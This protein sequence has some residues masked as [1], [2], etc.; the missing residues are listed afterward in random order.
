MSGYTDVFTQQR[1]IGADSILNLQLVD[2]TPYQFYWP[3][4]NEDQASVIPGYLRI[5]SSVEGAGIV[6]PDA[7]DGSPGWGF[8]VNNLSTNV[9]NVS[10]ANGY[11]LLSLS[12]GQSFIFNLV[13]DT[14]LAGMWDYTVIG[15]VVSTYDATALAGQGLEAVASK[16]NAAW[17]ITYLSTSRD[18]GSSDRGTVINWTGGSG[19]LTLI[20]TDFTGTGFF[21]LIR[22][23]GTGPISVTP[24][25]GITLDE[26][27]TPLVI[28]PNE[29]AVISNDQNDWYSLLYNKNSSNVFNAINIAV[30]PRRASRTTPKR[31]PFNNFRFRNANSCHSAAAARRIQVEWRVW[32]GP[33]KI[34]IITIVER[35]WMNNT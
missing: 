9:L 17:P 35:I 27:V 8:R 30:N 7:R 15:T 4:Q 22:N 23:T 29:S 33:G 12:I 16:L 1:E 28:S 31:R 20:N 26:G 19:V 3:A 24:G 13:D 2:D 32:H 18:I 25:V 5:V 6:L 21:S 10:M 34:P 14:T 11:P